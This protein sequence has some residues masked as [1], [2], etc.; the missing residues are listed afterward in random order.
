MTKILAIETSCDETAAAV[1]EDGRRVHSN[2]VATQ[3]ELHR[4]FGG[5]FP[6]VA[7]R[8]HV[9]AIYPVI[10]QALAEAG[11][12]PRALDAIAVTHGPGLAGSLLVGVNA[13]K[14]LAFAAGRPLLAVNHLEGHIYSN[15]LE[16]PGAAQGQP[17]DQFPVIVLIVSGG[18]TELIEMRGHGRYR[19][20]GGT[21]DDAAGEAF[22]KVARLLNLGFPGGPAIERAAEGGN[23]SA[24]DLPRALRHDP[25]HRFDFSFSGLKT[26]ML[27]LTKRLTEQGMDL[28]EP[29]LLADLAASFQQAVADALVEKTAEAALVTGARQVCI[30]GGVSANRC[31]RATAR[32]RMA[33]LNIPL[34][35]PPL[36]YC[37][38]NA[39]MIGAAAYFNWLV[40]PRPE[41]GLGIDVYASLPLPEIAD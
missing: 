31:L 39:A 14:G 32:A 37:T 29:R 15:W 7:S 34:Y 38:D 19:R 13:A 36:A 40:N 2:V 5:V 35:I 8:Q 10:E 9:L 18:H 11:V 23:P 3:I 21:L 25:A 24:F 6:E 41:D 27:N 17:A 26:A 22:D 20:L 1:V 16:A 33:E 30:C 4:R 12:S 28:R